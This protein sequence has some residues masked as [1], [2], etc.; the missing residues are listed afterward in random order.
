MATGTNIC[1]NQEDALS[2]YL[3]SLIGVLGTGEPSFAPAVPAPAPDPAAPSA[4]AKRHYCFTVG[5]LRLALPLECVGKLA[6]FTECAGEGAS[7]L[8]LGYV[9]YNGRLVPVLAAGE[10]VMPGRPQPIPY[11]LIVVDA[12]GRFALA[13]HSIDPELD[14]RRE[15]VCWKTDRTARRWLAGTMIR[16]RCALL[17]TE[18]L[19]RIAAAEDAL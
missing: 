1:E 12:S 17:D 5:G 11:Q 9:E 18:E 13:C 6:K 14:V 15:D 16:K 7:A 10:L 8:H 4:I 2:L 19:A 3:D